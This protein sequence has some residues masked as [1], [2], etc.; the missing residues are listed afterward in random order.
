MA[1]VPTSQI[2]HKVGRA[3]KKMSTNVGK[4]YMYYLNRLILLRIHYPKFVYLFMKFLYMI[5][6]FRYFQSVNHSLTLSIKMLK[7][8]NREAKTKYGVNRDDFQALM[9]DNNYFKNN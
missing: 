3:R 9:I 8:L 2:Y 1:C 7:R 6:A 4:Y 5:N